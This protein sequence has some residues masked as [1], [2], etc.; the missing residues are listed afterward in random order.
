MSVSTTPAAAKASCAAEILWRPLVEETAAMCVCVGLLPPTKIRTAGVCLFAPTRHIH[1]TSTTIDQPST[2]VRQSQTR[3]RHP[4]RSVPSSTKSR[5][6][7]TFVVL[8]RAHR[9]TPVP[10]D[11]PSPN[12]LPPPL[13]PPPALPL[14]APPRPTSPPANQSPEH[15]PADDVP[16]LQRLRSRAGTNTQ[17]DRDRDAGVARMS[18]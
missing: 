17:G 16:S 11:P 14:K 7:L 2:T 15:P 3:P 8:S 13:Q 18:Q 12:A 4:C 10:A 9:T 5:T 1:V 6:H